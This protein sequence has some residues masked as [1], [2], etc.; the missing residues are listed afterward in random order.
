MRRDRWGGLAFRSF[1]AGGPGSATGSSGAACGPQLCP[2]P[3]SICRTI[4]RS[5]RC[6]EAIRAARVLDAIRSGSSGQGFGMLG[7]STR[8]RDPESG[9]SRVQRYQSPRFQSPEP[10]GDRTNRTPLPPSGPADCA[11][12]GRRS[13]RGRI[14]SCTSRPAAPGDR[15]RSGLTPVRGVVGKRLE[16]RAAPLPD[17]ACHVRHAVRAVASTRSGSTCRG[18]LE[19]ALPSEVLH[20]PASNSFLRAPRSPFVPGPPSP[21]RPRSGVRNPA[22]PVASLCSPRSATGSTR[23]RRARRPRSRGARPA[24]SSPSERDFGLGRLDIRSELLVRDRK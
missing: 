19:P 7:T 11:S 10:D 12:S 21:T 2:G 6:L 5:L 20:F 1:A 14:R 4:L 18:C 23:S 3:R 24:S 9:A 8:R 22:H 15:L 17:V 13:G 16:E